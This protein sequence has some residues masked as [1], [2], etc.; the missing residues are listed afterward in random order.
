MAA[1]CTGVVAACAGVDSAAVVCAAEASVDFAVAVSVA[2]VF[3]AVDFEAASE[4]LTAASVSAVSRD[5]ESF[6]SIRSTAGSTIRSFG[7]LILIPILILP[8][9]T[10]ILIPDMDRPVPA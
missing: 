1:A 2:A 9:R 8:T 4:A 6:Q 3:E 10:P 7:I 5:S